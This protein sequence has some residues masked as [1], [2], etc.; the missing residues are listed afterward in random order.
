MAKESKTA[1]WEE[2]EPKYRQRIKRLHTLN[3]V[4]F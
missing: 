2:I 4:A 1:S 3:N